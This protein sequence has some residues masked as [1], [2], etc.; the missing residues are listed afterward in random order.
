M[1]KLKIALLGLGNVGSGVYKILTTNKKIIEKRS[2]YEIEVAKI[3]VRNKN[4]KR[5]V[6]VDSSLITLKILLMMMKFPL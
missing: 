3:L 1:E 6:A 5:N 2:G 4:K